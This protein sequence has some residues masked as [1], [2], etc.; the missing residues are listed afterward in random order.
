[1]EIASVQ[2]RKS[3]A[4]GVATQ[5]KIFVCDA[6]HRCEVY[7][8]PTNEW[9]TI[10]SLN[11]SPFR[12][13][14]M[15]CLNEIVYV[16]GTVKEYFSSQRPSQPDEKIVVKPDEMVVVKS[17]D[18]KLGKWIQK[19][20]IP[21]N[22]NSEIKKHSFHCSTLKIAKGLLRKPKIVTID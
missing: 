4:F 20:S 19:T 22:K 15:V 11:N 16:V 18:P 5:G 13:R 12:L 10:A 7:K 6:S 3:S 21:I 9:Q 8:V 17:Y 2:T 14:C 1:M